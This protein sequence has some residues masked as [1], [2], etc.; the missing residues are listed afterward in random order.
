MFVEFE[1]KQDLKDLKNNN[2]ELRFNY[3][4]MYNSNLQ[5]VNETILI[6]YNNK[7]R[8]FNNGKY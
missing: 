2:F 1:T 4:V 3:Y 7:T 5:R 6:V 8:N